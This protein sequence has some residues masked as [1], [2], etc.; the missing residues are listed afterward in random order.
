MNIVRDEKKISVFSASV[1]VCV[2][3]AECVCVHVSA[4]FEQPKLT[5]ITNPQMFFCL[6]TWPH[7]RSTLMTNMDVNDANAG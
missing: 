2:C 3:R 4:K 5:K 1:S 7:K 6:Q